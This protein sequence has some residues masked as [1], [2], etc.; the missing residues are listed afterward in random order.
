MIDPCLS[1]FRMCERMERG[2]GLNR[3]SGDTTAICRVSVPA[4]KGST[5]CWP[6]YDRMIYLAEVAY[7]PFNSKL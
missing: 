5:S 4:S 3:G 7:L 6:L 1:Q 2:S